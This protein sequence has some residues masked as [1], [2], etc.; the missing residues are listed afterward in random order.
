MTAG[1]SQSRSGDRDV[2]RSERGE[3]RILA[4][5]GVRRWQQLSRRL[6][7]QDE[8]ALGGLQVKRGIGKAALKLPH[9][10]GTSEPLDVLARVALER[11][12]VEA[13]RLAPATSVVTTPSISELSMER[14]ASPDSAIAR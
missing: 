3:D 9:G 11:G 1:S 13:V 14:F 7:A 8:R 4:V 5:D 6:L 12:H 10:D 2:G